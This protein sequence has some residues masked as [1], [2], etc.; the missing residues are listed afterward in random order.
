MADIYNLY[1]AKT[2][3][4]ELVERAVAGEEILIAKAGVPKV[5]LVPVPQAKVL[6]EPGGSEGKIRYAPDWDAP[7]SEEDVQEWHGPDADD[8]LLK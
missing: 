6:R 7:M 2:N 3:L 8:P 1:E 4:S 5:R